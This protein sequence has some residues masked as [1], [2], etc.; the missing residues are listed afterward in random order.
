MPP[1]SSTTEFCVIK[2]RY[3]I[4]DTKSRQQVLEFISKGECSVF[5][6]A[7]ESALMGAINNSIYHAVAYLNTGKKEF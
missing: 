6:F 1:T 5:F 3:V 4:Y 7:F 2:T